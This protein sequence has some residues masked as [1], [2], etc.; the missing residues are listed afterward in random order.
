MVSLDA[1]LHTHSHIDTSS[2]MQEKRDAH[3]TRCSDSSQQTAERRRVYNTY[4]YKKVKALRRPTLLHLG[5]SR[6]L[7]QGLLSPRRQQRISKRA[8]ALSAADG[9]T[10]RREQTRR[11]NK[12]ER[13]RERFQTSLSY[14]YITHALFLVLSDA[15]FFE[16]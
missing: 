5:A 2:C 9:D 10:K 16:E 7:A 8:L 11:R 13:E 12:R 15:S 3:H 14:M 1:H 4:I 6:D